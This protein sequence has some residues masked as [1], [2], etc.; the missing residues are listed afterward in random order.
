V[1]EFVPSRFSETVTQLAIGIEPI[2]AALR[3]RVP[4]PLQVSFDTAPFKLS[5]P[6]IDHHRTGLH[7]LVYNPK[8]RAPVDLRFDDTERRYVARR[9]RFPMH[10]EAIAKSS[11]V[12]H[13][14]RRPAMFPGSAYDVSDATGIRGSV[15]RGGLPMRWARVEA[16]V[17]GRGALVG[18]A[19]G[20]DRGE[21]LLLIGPEIAPPGDLPATLPVDVQVFGPT[22]PPVPATPDIPLI[23]PLWDLPLEEASAPG[24]PDPVLNGE[25]QP[26]SYTASTTQTINLAPGQILSGVV[27]ILI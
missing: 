6:A 27:F 25:I 10:T 16:R 18:R 9:L 23:D 26:A 3:L 15:Q 1:N 4:R 21:F 19:H 11:P 7:V 24:T 8:L 2:D 12:S 17:Q 22:V 14:V 5:R 13:R 20:D